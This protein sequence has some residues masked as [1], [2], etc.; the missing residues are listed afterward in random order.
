MNPVSM[1]L[2][3]QHLVCRQFSSSEE[4]VDWMGA[5]QAQDHKGIH[6][7]VAM[8]TK[9]PSLKSFKDA[10]DSGKIVRFHLMR[11]TWQ[12][13][14]AGDYWQ[15]LDLCAPKAIAVTRGWMATNRI[16]IQDDEAGRIRDIL[17]STADSL[18]SATKEDFIQALGEKGIT[19]DDHRLSYH[20][21]LSEMSGVLCSGNMLPLKATYALA[22]RKLPA[23]TRTD[24]DEALM[25]LTR[26]YFRSRQPATLEDFAWWSGLSKSDC[27]KGIS[28]LG[29]W[30]HVERW[31]GREYFVTD[32]CRSRGWRSGGV[33]LLPPYDEYLIS[34]KS[35]EIVVPQEHTHRAHNNSGNF[36][37]VI[38]VD[39]KAAGNWSMAKDRI[40]M[41]FFRE[42][43]PVE[44]H[45]LEKELDRYEYFI[46]H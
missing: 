2:L 10:F 37:P 3:S 9:R 20:I 35:R 38:L 45:A 30:L 28:L 36:W 26:K 25:I 40:S 4:V 7:A 43:L 27:L 8:R 41:E 5:M 31:R 14:S 12:L 42:G 33:L 17:A 29:D 24:R 16:S 32:E 46:N 44:P 18:G 19:M 21:R 39:G 11:G 22:E 1:R 6:W 13:V 34:Y 15:M 23:R